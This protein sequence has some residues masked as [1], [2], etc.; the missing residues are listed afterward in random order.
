MSESLLLAR[1]IADIHYDDI[2]V[3]AIDAAKKSFLD[4]LG[5]TL[6]AS[7][8]GEGCQAFVDLALAMEGVQESTILGFGARAPALMAAFAN[9]SMA[10]ALDFEDVHDSAPVHPNAATIPAALAVAESVGDVSGKR[11][12]T[13]MV[14]GCDLTC[15]LGLALKENPLESG[16]YIPPILG[17]FGAT[18]AACKLLDPTAEQVVDAFSLTL[19]QTTCS[20]ELTV[21]PRSVVRSVRDAFSAKAGVLSAL[22]AQRGVTGFERPIEGEGGLFS[23]Y[24]RGNYDPMPLTNELGRTFEGANVSVKPWPS[25]RGTHA[26]IEAALHILS[27]TSLEPSEVAGIKVVVSPVNKMLCEPQR[28]KKKPATAIDAKFSIPFVLATALLRG[29]VRLD[30]FTPRALAD[31]DVLQ[32]AGKVTY[33]VDSGLTLKEAVRGFVQ[34]DTGEAT[35]SR[36]VD[37]PLGHPQNPIS[38]ETLVSKFMDCAMHSARRISDRKLEEVVELTAN[39]E[40]VEDVREITQHL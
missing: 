38:Q 21:S 33:E 24:S 7:T 20:A 27:E 29:G 15:R 26:Y 34:I 39:L 13:A 35:L 36:R 11:F 28:S 16:W 2:P 1:N 3:P 9:G 37:L 40:Q 5:V 30:H 18:A 14:L 25:C 22:L 19:C 6:A 4:A 8:L 10:H 31:Q 17:A 12:L 32:M 23:L